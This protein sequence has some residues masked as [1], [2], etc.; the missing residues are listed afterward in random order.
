MCLSTRFV[1]SLSLIAVYLAY[2][3]PAAAADA[4]SSANYIFKLLK[5][6][7]STEYKPL[8]YRVYSRI[9]LNE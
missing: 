8:V 9:M 7:N 1:V 3:L 2:S 4:V 5:L 6:V